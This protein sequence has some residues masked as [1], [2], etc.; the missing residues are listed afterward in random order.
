[1]FVSFFFS[2]GLNMKLVSTHALTQNFLKHSMKA[3]RSGYTSSF[4]VYQHPP[5]CNQPYC[6]V[7]VQVFK[8]CECMFQEILLRKFIIYQD[9]VDSLASWYWQPSEIEKKETGLL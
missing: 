9:C 8:W 3:G 6:N 5:Y 7:T 4:Q 1:M 2:I